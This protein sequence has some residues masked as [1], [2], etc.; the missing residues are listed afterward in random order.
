MQNDI[1]KGLKRI[2]ILRRCQWGI[3]FGFIPLALLVVIIQPSNWIMNII[4]TL[5]VLSFVIV[6][7][8]HSFYPCPVCHRIF[9]TGNVF[10]NLYENA[11]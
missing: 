8:V 5:Y 1:Q 6:G 10:T 3:F 11:L 2:L 7:L 9:N 4:A